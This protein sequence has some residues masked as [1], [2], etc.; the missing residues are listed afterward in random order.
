VL[1]DNGNE[2]PRGSSNV[3]EFAVEVDTIFSG[4]WNNPEA[5]AAAFHYGRYL[6]GD[7]GY[8]DH[9]GYAYIV[10]RKRD[11]ILSGGANVYPAEVERV[12]RE[13][14]G[15]ADIAVFGIPHERWG[16]TVA[17]AIVRAPG[18]T[19]TE[20]EVIAFAQKSMAGFKKPTSVR[21]VDEL[22]RNASQKVVKDVLRARWAS[23]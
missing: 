7:V 14:E 12:L 20:D 16:E 10:D 2:L 3:G 13:L 15:V 4:Y 19:L 11:M 23:S 21:F 9:A 6:T 1:D 8:V 22:P 18:S 5:T 17:A